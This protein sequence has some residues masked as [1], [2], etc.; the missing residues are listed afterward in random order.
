MKKL[1]PLLFLLIYVC[2]ANG[3]M[4]RKDLALIHVNVFNGVDNTITQDAVILIKNGKI[5][6]IGRGGEVIPKSYEVVDCMGNYAMPGMID[7]H[8]HVE[9][10]DEAKRALQSGVTT[11][12]TAGVG[13]Y[14]DVSIKELTL[15]GRI[16][17]P[18]VIPAGVFVTPNLGETVLADPRLGNLITGVNTDEELRQIVNVNLDRG[19]LVIKTRGTE[20]AG[21]P[22]TDPRQQSYTQHQLK[23]IVDEAAKRNISVMVHAH[24]DEGGRAAVLAGARS[25]EHGTFLSDQTLQLMKEKGVYLV[26]TFITLEDLSKPNGDYGGAVLEMRGRFMMPLGEKV[27]K[28]A[29][30]L[31]VKI[32]TGADTNY[33]NKSTSRV[34]MECEH[35]VRLGMSNFQAIQCTTTTAA[36]LLGVGSKTG[37]LLPGFEADLVVLPANPLE[38]IR[39]LQD[40]LIVISNGY[41]GLKRL[42]FGKE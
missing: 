17:G 13:A 14:Q 40:A 6:R 23:V 11:I 28:K 1:T 4:A 29:Q 16:A 15:S 30:A 9:S 38:D 35:Y 2:P 39:S 32:A 10:L 24:G 31:G 26:P 36:D 21:L 25:I 34:S 27:I 8:T 7:V 33:D 12:R 42:P 41:I 19:A 3:Q 20:R 22:D 5:E 37:R 18:D